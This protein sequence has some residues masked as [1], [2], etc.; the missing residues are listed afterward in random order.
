ML[1]GRI[2]G[3]SYTGT[4]SSASTTLHSAAIPAGARHRAG[5]RRRPA[6]P[7]AAHSGANTKS[8]RTTP[9]AAQIAMRI[10]TAVEKSTSSSAP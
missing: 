7:S 2:P 1:S 10:N 9:A 5:I 8:C 4:A 6:K 3:L